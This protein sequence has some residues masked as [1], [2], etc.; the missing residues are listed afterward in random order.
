M[1]EYIFIYLYICIQIY[2]YILYIRNCKNGFA[3]L[4]LKHLIFRNRFY[5]KLFLNFPLPWMDTNKNL[6]N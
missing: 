2:A 3:H 4:N 5:S 1:N 6:H